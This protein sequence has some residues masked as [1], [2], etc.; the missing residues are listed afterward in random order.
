MCRYGASS[1]EESPILGISSLRRSRFR[2]VL[3]LAVVLYTTFV[4]AVFTLLAP[5]SF[6]QTPTDT[7]RKRKATTTE[8]HTT[9]DDTIEWSWHYFNNNSTTLRRKLLIAQYVGGGQDYLEMMELTSKASRAY[10][11]KW[12]CDYLQQKGIPIGWKPE[13]ATYNKPPVLQMAL[14]RQGYDAV[15]LL[16]ADAVIVDHDFDILELLSEEYMIAA[17]AVNLKDPHTTNINIGV[18][19][20]NLRHPNTREVVDEW[21]RLSR[22]RAYERQ[23]KRTDDQTLLHEILRVKYNSKQRAHMIQALNTSHILYRRGTAVRHFIRRDGTKWGE[24]SGFDRVEEVRAAV[25][26]VCGPNLVE[27][28]L[29]Q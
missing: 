12:N 2:L 18:T 8:S 26:E 22:K 21:H 7:V 6:L 4:G 9:Q 25:Q 29:C 14:S 24:S 19:L 27:N 20:W 13:H 16:D 5:V 23:T 3:V 11:R 10:A 28:S 1:N 17:Q 15:L